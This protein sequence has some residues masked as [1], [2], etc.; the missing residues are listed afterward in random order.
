MRFLWSSEGGESLAIARRVAREGHEVR[1][2]ILN[3]K[4]RHVGDGLID[5]RDFDQRRPSWA[6][7][8]VY[9]T[10]CPDFAREADTFRKRG[11]PVI[12]A[13]GLGDRMEHDRMY[14]IELVE[15]LGIEAPESESFQGARAFKDAEK[16]IETWD[17]E[18]GGVLKPDGTVDLKTFVAS[19]REELRRMLKFWEKAFADERATP[20]FLIEK[21]VD[22]VEIST[23]AWWTGKDWLLPNHTLERSRLCCGD[24]GRLTGC[25]GNLVWLTTERE[26]LFQELFGQL[27]EVIGDQYH[28]PV[29]INAIVRDDGVPVFLEF[30]P[31]FGYSA[32]FAF[33]ELVEE[34]G[35]FLAAV[36]M[37]ERW[38]GKVY[39]DRYAIGVR[40][41]IPPYPFSD[42]KKNEAEGY[43][44]RG[45]FDESPHHHPCEIRAVGN[46][47]YETTGPEGIVFEVT[48]TE[49]SVR[50]A[51]D[52]LYGHVEQLQVPYLSYRT[53]I[54]R[55]CEQEDLDALQRMRL[56]DLPKP[57]KSEFTFPSRM[58]LKTH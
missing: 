7:V 44:V 20:D 51:S 16:Y 47:E 56:V 42:P 28:G 8:L 18:Q 14:A 36:A 12:G 26:P 50:K 29:D 3:P 40:C 10:T 6:D 2:A 48:A 25:Q 41:T 43:P 49:D 30:S 19:D 58:P 38:H 55:C 13:S 22:G 11:I 9:D 32:I 23:E 34:M 27:G 39:R 52:R 57:P 45:W 15:N 35:D 21:T 5:K 33:S 37:G 1:F 17:E 24:L 4:Y 31:R 54:G 53:D 46:D